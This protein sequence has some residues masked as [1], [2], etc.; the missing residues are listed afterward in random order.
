[1]KLEKVWDH[2]AFLDYCDRWMYEDDTEFLKVMKEATT[3][4]SA[5][6]TKEA[7]G[8]DYP[9]LWAHQGQCWDDFPK[10]MWKKYRQAAGMPPTDGWKTK[11]P[12]NEQHLS[13]PKASGEAAPA[14]ER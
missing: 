10:D 1:M 7:A 11:K 4:K 8:L 12:N 2:D 9:G 14:G 5:A 3:L 6:T 13:A